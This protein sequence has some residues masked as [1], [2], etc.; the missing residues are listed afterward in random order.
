[1]TNKEKFMALVSPEKTS[2]I[3]EIKARNK[4]RAVL[5]ESQKIAF[6]VLL[7]LD[8]LG[9]SQKD[10]AKAMA[11]TPQQVNKIVSGKE[12]LTLKTQVK[13]QQVLDIAILASYHDDQLKQLEDIILKFGITDKY[14]MLAPP[15]ENY[16]SGK[17]IRM[18][19]NPY[20]G[21][22]LYKEVN[23]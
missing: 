16:V 2:T 3:S 13:L 23:G 10:L 15:T 18:E 5:R 19:P 8:D 17:C 6:K 7:K 9:W 1:M 11:I 14:Q 20:S 21:A 4:N 22:C 12:N